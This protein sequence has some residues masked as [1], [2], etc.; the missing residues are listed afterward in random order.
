MFRTLLMLVAGNVA[1]L[2]A[3]LWLT[4]RGPAAAVRYP[5]RPI[6]LVVPFSQGG[7]SDIFARIIKKAIDDEGLLPQP[8]TII[9]RDGAGA[10]TGSRYVKNERPDGYTLMVLHDAIMT[11]RCAGIVDYGPEAFVPVAAT[12]ELGMVLAVSQDSPYASLDDLVRHAATAPRM[13]RFGAN[14]GALSHFAGMQLEQAA[15]ERGLGT[16]EFVYPQVGGGAERFSDLLGGHIDLTAFSI[17]EFTRFAPAGLKGIAYLGR[18]RHPAAVD[19]PTAIEQGYDI[20]NTNTF[21]WWF[22]QGTPADRVDVIRTALQRAMDTDYVRTKLAEIQC[23]PVFVTGDALKERLATAE[24]R[25]ARTQI[26]ATSTSLNLPVLL[27]WATAAVLSVL[28]VQTLLKRKG[29]VSHELMPDTGE[30][31]DRSAHVRRRTMLAIVVI[32]LY[33]A[34]LSLD[35]GFALATSIFVPAMGALLLTSP[36]LQ[37]LLVLLVIGQGM[38]FGLSVLF[39]RVFDVPLP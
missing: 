25:L 34:V 26:C 32:A 36:A 30:T 38:G 7:G 2:C 17:E 3:G 13:V 35:V 33:T 11:A 15:T 21:Y 24:E 6:E 8:L 9:N 23:E 37:P 16:V 27:L 22:P 4:M 31:R 19:V 18:Q 39:D 14:L 29:A 20:I 5:R 12:G 1:V 28:G 10:T